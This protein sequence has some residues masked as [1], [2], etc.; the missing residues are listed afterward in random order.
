VTALQAARHEILVD[1]E[2]PRPGQLFGRLEGLTLR[3]TTIP[4]G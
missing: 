1:E 4:I 3:R 2:H